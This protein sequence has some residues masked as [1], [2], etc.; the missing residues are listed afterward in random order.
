MNLAEF[1]KLQIHSRPLLQIE[2]F[3]ACTVN[4][5]MSIVLLQGDIYPRSLRQGRRPYISKRNSAF[6]LG[7]HYGVTLVANP[8]K[9]ECI[10]SNVIAVKNEFA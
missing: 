2:T 3:Y 10:P 6:F 4:Y 7:G 1:G 5:S 9:V 8:K